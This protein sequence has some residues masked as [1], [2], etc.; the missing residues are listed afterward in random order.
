MKKKKFP[1]EKVLKYRSY[2]EKNQAALFSQAMRLEQSIE[3]ALTFNQSKLNKNLNQKDSMLSEGK[4]N[5][6]KL[7]AIQEEILFTQ[8]DDAVLHNELAKASSKSEQERLE[9]L[10]RKGDTD[11]IDKLEIKFN[12]LVDKENLSD[13]QKEIDEIAQQLYLNAKDDK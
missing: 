2:L 12:D 7:K 5:I 9:W 13:E 10:Q 6:N 1:L 8:V 4:L 3:T 11:A